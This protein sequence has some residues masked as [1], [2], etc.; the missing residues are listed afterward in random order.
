AETTWAL[1]V[2]GYLAKLVLG[3]LGLIVSVA[4]VAHIIIYLLI[5]PPLSPFLNE[6]FIKLDDVWGLLGT[7][8]FAFFCFYLLLAVIAGATMLGLRLVFITIHPMK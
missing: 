5:N 7:A 6:V 2:L 3:I 1:T 8:A 4:W